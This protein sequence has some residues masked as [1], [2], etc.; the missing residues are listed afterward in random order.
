MVNTSCQSALRLS[1]AFPGMLIGACL[2]VGVCERAA[3]AAE[4]PQAASQPADN[5]GPWLR[6]NQVG[7]L[8]A[9]RKIAVLS[10]DGP[11]TGSFS[12]G[13]FTAPLGADQGAWGPFK[14]NYRLDF[15]SVTQPG[16]HTL[17]CGDD[18]AQQI[19]ISP[20][21]Y[22]E[23]PEKL[24]SF[25]RLQR[26]GNNPVTGKTCHQQDAID[27]VTGER[28]DL[29]GGW[30]DAADRIKHQIT[31]TYCVAALF[32]A[33]AQEEARYGAELVRKLHP[34]GDVI[35]VQIG[36]DRDHMPPA[37]LWHEDKSNYG[38]G[39]GGPRSAWPAT[40]QPAGPKHQNKSSGLASLAGRA[41]AA[42]ALCGDLASARSLYE[43]AREHPGNAMSVPVK[44]P[45]YYVE[46]TFWDDL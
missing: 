7:Y 10:S 8:P 27:T 24:L 18:V 46:I 41:A 13:S 33:G 3:P 25:M 42:M 28:V 29:V 37:G 23:I 14:H 20:T 1:R 19:T 44:A 40:T 36:D 38:W 32:L 4:A 15:T 16:T 6:V 9:D 43:L 26:C 22:A 30:H 45:Y 31:T 17:R 35:Y 2:L 39:A 5:A 34:H 12:V 11:L 21:A